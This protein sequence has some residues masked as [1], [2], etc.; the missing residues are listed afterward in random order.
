MAHVIASEYERTDGTEEDLRH[1]HN[2]RRSNH[3]QMDEKRPGK[4]GKGTGGP[5]NL[6]DGRKSGR[7]VARFDGAGSQRDQ[8]ERER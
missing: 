6:P 8:V 5:S 3:V 7:P 1:P 4:R 2:P